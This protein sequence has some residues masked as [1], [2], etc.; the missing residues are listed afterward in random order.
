MEKYEKLLNMIMDFNSDVRF[1]AVVNPQGE[2]L[3]NTQRNDLKKLI[4]VEDTKRTI[5]LD[6]RKI[7][8]Y[9]RVKN[10]LGDNRYSITSY[11]KIKRVAVPLKNGNM[12]FFSI[13]NTPLDKSKNKSYGKLVEM[14]KILSIVEFIEA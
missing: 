14:G 13:N 7:E 9:K 5:Q 3:W 6:L 2:I 4:P 10:Y 11:E 1:A 8:D 12:L